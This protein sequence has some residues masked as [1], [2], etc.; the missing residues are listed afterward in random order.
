M[1]WREY[2]LEFGGALGFVLAYAVLFLLAKQLN[3]LL[4]PYKLIEELAVKD[5]PAVGIALTGYLLASALVFIGPLL[6]PTGDYLTDLLTV[7]GYALLGLVFINVSRWVLDKFIFHHFC[8]WEALIDNQNVGMGAVRFGVYVATGLVAAGSVNGNGGGVV[9]ALV[10]FVLGQGALLLFSRIYDLT[11]SYELHEE[12]ENGNVA[13]GVAF[14]GT[15]LAL[16][17][18]I[19]K[20]A[21]GSFVS[22]EDNL[23]DFVASTLIGI[24]V[25]QEVRVFMDKLVLTGHDLNDEIAKDRNLAAGFL[26][27]GVAIAFALVLAA[28][29]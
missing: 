2:L 5:N 11:T 16:G 3:D 1:E 9:T 6:G 23:T 8:N 22:W 4:S 29:L 13:A 26:E 27:M 10:F 21:S 12:I 24:I 15:V 20:A 18:I 28:L 19:G 7:A 17:I 14:G 25:L